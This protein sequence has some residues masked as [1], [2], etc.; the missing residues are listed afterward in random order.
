MF[1][2]R[3]QQL[4]E[5]NKIT[6]VEIAKLCN[7]TQSAVSS[8]KKGFT[9]HPQ[10]LIIL[11]NYFGVTVD[12]LLGNTNLQKEITTTEKQIII[13]YNNAPESIKTAVNKLLD[14]TIL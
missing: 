14:L 4:L 13:K 6:Q 5:K 11:A 2:K 3:F 10:T 7:I 12:Y 9:P 8:W 1:W